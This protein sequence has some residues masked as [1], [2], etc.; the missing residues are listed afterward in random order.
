MATMSK[1]QLQALLAEEVEKQLKANTAFSEL[2][3]DKINGMVQDKCAELTEE[4]TKKLEKAVPPVDDSKGDPKGGFK[5]IAEFADVVRKADMGIGLD[6]RL[7]TKAAGT[8]MLEGDADYGGYLV[9]EEFRAQILQVALNTSNLIQYC[10][11]I[12]M[13]TN[14]V[15]IP[16]I[17]ETSRASTVFGGI[18]FYWLDEAGEISASRPKTGNVNM[19]LK[20]L[21]GMAY[22]TDEIVQD[23]PVSAEPLIT[24]LFGQGLAFTLEKVFIRGTGAGQPLGVLNAPCLI[25]VAKEGAQN[26]DTIIYENVA[27]MYSRMYDG[28]KGRGIWLANGDTLPQ[29]LIMNVSVGTGGAPVWIPAGGASGAP[30]NTL[31]GRPIFFNEHCSTVGDVGDIIFGDWSQYLVGQKSGMGGGVQFATSIHLKFDYAQTAYRVITRV[32]GQPW[33]ASAQTPAQGSN[34]VGP[35]V[36]VATR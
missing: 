1:E 35:F 18:T 24:N 16:Y 4:M 8:G 29:L 36:A 26:A 13:A 20:K 11:V 3:I 17:N 30:Y 19:R 10:T 14:S 25:S 9:P 27:K 33:W 15:N 22:L 12:P 21:A 5:S 7:A 2:S 32:D 31:I 28:G 23:S 6:K 34:T